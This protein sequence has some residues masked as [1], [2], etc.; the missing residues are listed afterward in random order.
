MHPRINHY[1]E[2]W[3]ADWCHDHGWTDYFRES[4]SYWAFPPQAVMPCPLPEPALKSI[5]AENGLSS[6]EKRWFSLALLS[7]VSGTALSFAINQP[8]PLI[9]G[10]A[11]CAIVVGQM[12]DE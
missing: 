4:T 2:H 6:H 3:I 9:L 8:L 7:L 12:D 5:K 1:C 11:F 10:F